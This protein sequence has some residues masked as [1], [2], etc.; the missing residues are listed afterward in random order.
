MRLRAV[1]G[2]DEDRR[3]VVGV[4]EQPAR[5]AR[6]RVGGS[7]GS[8]S[9]TGRPERAC[10]APGPCP[11]RSRGASGRDPSR[12]SRR[13]SHGFV[14]EQVLGEREPAVG[15]LVD[16]AE[17]VLLVL[18]AEVLARR[19]CTRRRPARP[20]GG[21]SA[22]RCTALRSTASGSS[23]TMHAVERPRRERAG[24]A[25]HD[26]ALAAAR[27]RSPTGA[28]R[29]IAVPLAMY[30]CRTSGRQRLRKP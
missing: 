1:V 25:E 2:D 4:L 5:S 27:S 15:H 13:S 16:L 23:V 11:S 8:R 29:V 14:V 12:P 21:A 24:H 19:T 10:G 28:A 26:R 30:I 7:R 6:R 20:R 17:E 9:R 18:G 3:L 22:G